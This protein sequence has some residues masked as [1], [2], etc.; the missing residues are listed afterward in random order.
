MRQLR[1]LFIV[2]SLFCLLLQQ[3]LAA[4]T[5]QVTVKGQ[6]A[7]RA[8]LSI[9]QDDSTYQVKLSL[10]PVLLA[11][12][13]GIDDMT[14]T[15][16]GV[17][18]NGHLYPQ[19]YQRLDKKDQPLLSVKF[20]GQQAHI[21]SAEDGKK[22]L[23]IHK[24]G[25][26]PLSQMAQ[27]AYDLKHDTLQDSYYLVTENSQQRYAAKKQGQKVTLTQQPSKKRQ[28][29]LWFDAQY[30]LIKMQKNKKDKVHFLMEKT[31]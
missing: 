15:A 18:R 9:Q 17:V 1:G 13:F 25:Q 24:K 6:K 27:I 31:E 29:I 7:G 10:F 19:H 30:Q 23:P 22:T 2:I 5:Y 16:K 8:V 4:N 3:A 11:K 14:E 20:G 28:L 21:D 12:M 26:D